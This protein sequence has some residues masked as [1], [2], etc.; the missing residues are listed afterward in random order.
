MFGARFK[1][2]FGIGFLCVW[3]GISLLALVMM[4]KLWWSRER[5]NYGG[6]DRMEQV[7]AVCKNAGIRYANLDAFLGETHDWGPREIYHVKGDHNQLSYV[8]YLLAPHVPGESDLA[9]TFASET[10]SIKGGGR[11]SGSDP[12][13]VYESTRSMWAWL[14][15]LLVA[16]GCLRLKGM[17]APLCCSIRPKLI[18]TTR[19]VFLSNPLAVAKPHLI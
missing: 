9:V 12:P 7:A 4:Y 17:G 3:A 8:K 16:V 13:H 6:K 19:L 18:P 1:R 15:A 2:V 10:L 14:G 5:V 11:R